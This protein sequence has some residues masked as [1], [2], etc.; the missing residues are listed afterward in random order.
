MASLDPL[1]GSLGMTRAAHLLR[2]ATFRPTRANIDYYKGRTADQAVNELFQLSPL[3]ISGPQDPDSINETW[4]D[5]LNYPPDPGEWI[6]R[7]YVKSWWL[8]EAMKDD[9]IG[10]K[11][12]FFLHSNFVAS[13]D[14]MNH[15]EYH[16]YL[17]L[18]RHYVKG[19]YKMLAKKISINMVMMYYL[20]G[21]DNHK[22]SP[23]EN[24]GREFLE[25]FTIGKGPLIGQ[26]N[27]THYTETDVQEA[28][29]V[30]TGWRT[31]DDTQWGYDNEV[32]VVT[33]YPTNW[34]HD[35]TDKIFSDAFDNTTI[36]GQEN[37]ENH[38]QEIDDFVEMVF[39]KIETAKNFCRKLY[40]Y[41]VS[42]KLTSEIES[43]IITPMA[44][45]LFN[46]NYVIENT[47][48]MLLK[49]KHFYDADDNTAGDEIIG[50]M[51]K[52]PL[53]ILGS[54]I[55][56]FQ[57]PIPDRYSDLDNHYRRFYLQT[58][59][60]NAFEKA[61][62]KLFEPV[63]VAGYPDLYQEP[64]YYRL[65][66]T[67]NT[68]V[69]RYKTPEM[70]LKGKRILEWGDSG[71]APFDMIDFIDNSGVITNPSSASGLVAEL[72]EYLFPKP[73]SSER[74]DYFLNDVFLNDLPEFDWYIDWTTYKQNGD[75]SLVETP[76]NN[77]FI[78]I[79]SS[80]E[81]QLM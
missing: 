73:P 17:K 63:T 16:D 4:I 20:D 15:Y 44:Q 74:A 78:A 43:D 51:M 53:D 54:I 65:R 60:D 71:A 12:E 38:F 31:W 24:Y 29:R 56:F 37:T 41:F 48:K 57:T 68:I 66:M 36:T 45:Q 10:H 6:L 81:F 35:K 27:Y 67:S 2:R 40:R 3:T 72:T 7:H 75:R 8:D 5:T 23:N 13:N 46:D 14:G 30:F 64:L 52:S 11:L 22:D 28:A 9:S 39:G 33:A 77:L 47:L 55:N 76:L 79:C 58:I 61:S 80:Q 50:A 59:Q 25:L 49:S 34:A 19:D 70:I 18:L 1:T 26:G 21:N 69:A 42:H 62:F 32:G